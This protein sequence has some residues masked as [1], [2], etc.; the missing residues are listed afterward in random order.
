MRY[1][2]RRLLVVA[3]CGIAYGHAP[4][5]N[6]V[7]LAAPSHI[8]TPPPLLVLAGHDGSMPMVD[9][10][11]QRFAGHVTALGRPDP[12]G[13]LFV[14]ETAALRRDAARF[15]PGSLR[16]WRLTFVSGERLGAVFRVA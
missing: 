15:P 4:T 6:A 13:R 16:S 11:V 12:N 14:F 2:C 9:P 5:G 1:R 8:R 10:I 7:P 3:A